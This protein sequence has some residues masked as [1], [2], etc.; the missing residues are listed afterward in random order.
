MHF[1]KI[2]PKLSNHHTCI[3]NEN[4]GFGENNFVVSQNFT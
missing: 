4:G 2:E 3:L 1:L